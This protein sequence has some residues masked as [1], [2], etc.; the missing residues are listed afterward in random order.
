MRHEMKSVTRS[1][2]FRI[3]YQTKVKKEHLF[4]AQVNRFLSCRLQ[5][6]PFLLALT[7]NSRELQL[8]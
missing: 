3:F 2:K 5:V 7:G 1:L 8:D 6:S 4:V